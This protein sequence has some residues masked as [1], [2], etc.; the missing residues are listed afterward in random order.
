M[1]F[2]PIF[3]MTYTSP[4]GRSWALFMHALGPSTLL[5]LSYL[6]NHVDAKYLLND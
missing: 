6:L 5:V 4:A 3:S 1:T 2:M